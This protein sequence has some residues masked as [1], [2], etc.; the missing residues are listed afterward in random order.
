MPSPAEILTEAARAARESIAFAAAWH[1]A[2]LAAAIA[3]SRGMRPSRRAA[4]LAIAVLVLS[5]AWVAFRFGNPFNAA[6]LAF[7]AGLLFAVALRLGMAPAE[8]GA[9]WSQAAGLV[10][11]A[12][13]WCYPHFL[14]DPALYAVA[15]PLGVLP[16]PTLCAAAGLTLLANGFSSRAWTLSLAAFAAFYGAVG[17]FRLGV[18]IDL[19]LLAG[20]IALVAVVPKRASRSAAAILG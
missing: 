2:L 8:R 9:P 16:C 5:P 17:A 10:L 13:G 15:A 18:W 3:L 6:V 11:V 19:I 14:E 7:A 20:A 12:F 4:G 1:L